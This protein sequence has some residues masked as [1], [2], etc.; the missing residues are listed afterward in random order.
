MKTIRS[1][2]AVNLELDTVRAIAEQQRVLRERCDEA[3]AKVRW[4]P[5]PNMH[6]TIRFLGQVTEPMVQSLKDALETVTRRHGPFD[7]L[8]RGLGAFPDAARAKVLWVGVEADG[9]LE[10]LYDDV[11]SCLDETGFRAEKRPFRS[12]LTIGRVKQAGS[13]DAL[14]E[15]LAA[16]AEQEF[17]GSTIRDLICYR[18]DLQPHGAD[19]R[20]MWRLPLTGRRPRDASNGKAT[21]PQ[22]AKPR[23]E[24]P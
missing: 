8:A 11:S 20:V 5:P 2:L 9:Y 13:G 7:A 15:C 3:G 1:F 4:I 6:V 23:S 22:P 10:R 12:H 19:Y 16:G 17:G 14:A 21:P 18:S 24:T